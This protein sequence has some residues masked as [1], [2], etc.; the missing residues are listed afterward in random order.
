[1]SWYVDSL[2]NGYKT[3]RI[4][5]ENKIIKFG[6]G[7]KIAV[8]YLKEVDRIAFP[9]GFSQTKYKLMKLITRSQ[10]LF[11]TEKQLR[12]FERTNQ[13]GKLDGLSKIL[14]TKVF[15]KNV[16]L[17]DLRPH[18]VTELRSDCDYWQYNKD[19][20]IGLGFELLTLNNSHKGS[21]K[22]VRN[23]LADKIQDGVENFNAALNLDRNLLLAAEFKNQFAALIVLRANAEMSLRDTLVNSTNE[24]TVMVV[25]P[26]NVK[27]LA[28][29]RPDFW[30]NDE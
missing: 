26:E 17:K 21:I 7:V 20:P 30:S 10:F 11:K 6:E 25:S 28:E 27:T 12:N 3:P 15:W 18:G 13:L 29:L 4:D 1:M 16:T 5:I 2:E 8:K 22:S 9:C 19:H 23:F 14:L 24:P